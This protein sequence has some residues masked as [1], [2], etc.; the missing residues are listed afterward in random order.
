MD[1]D[2]S[3][4]LPVSL[5]GLALNETSAPPPP[6]PS[7]PNSAEDSILTQTKN[8]KIQTLPIG[9]VDGNIFSTDLRNVF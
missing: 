4:I 9:F 5:P 3:A 2:L 6:P 8:N 7:S 1:L